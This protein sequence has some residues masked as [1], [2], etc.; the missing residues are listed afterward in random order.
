MA[1]VPPYHETSRNTLRIETDI[2][3]TMIVRMEHL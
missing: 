3:T 1:T 2:T